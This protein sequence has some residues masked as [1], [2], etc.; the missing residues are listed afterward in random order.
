MRPS[1]L[2]LCSCPPTCLPACSTNLHF[3]L[4]LSCFLGEYLDSSTQPNVLAPIAAT[5]AARAY[6]RA[7]MG[8]HCP[9]ACRGTSIPCC[10]MSKGPLCTLLQ[11]STRLCVL[12]ANRG[13]LLLDLVLPTFLTLNLTRTTDY[14]ILNFAVW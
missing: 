7:N 4:Q 1:S 5:P 8:G 13:N 12:R 14:M 10:G 6:M 9:Q 11:G 3:Y 2:G